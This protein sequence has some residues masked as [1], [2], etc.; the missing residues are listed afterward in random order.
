MTSNPNGWPPDKWD[1]TGDP[2]SPN[3]ETGVFVSDPMPIRPDP[4]LGVE[5]PRLFGAIRGA[6]N[7]W[8]IIQPDTIY[9]NVPAD[10]EHA[11]LIYDVVLHA[12]RDLVYDTVAEC[13]HPEFGSEWQEPDG[14]LYVLFKAAE[15]A[16]YQRGLK[17]KPDA[18]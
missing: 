4:L 5:Y 8:E 7:G 2:L 10:N 15:D 9:G 1:V 16:A 14:S 13:Y 17:E 18:D 6:I 3:G 12:V 11:R